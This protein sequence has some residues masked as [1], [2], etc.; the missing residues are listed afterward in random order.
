MS[1]RLYLLQRG[2]AVAMVPLI[3]VHL[4]LIFYAMNH[5]LTAASI[6]AR[7]QG[8][9][10]WGLFYG[11]FVLLAS[12]HASIGIR[13]ILAEWGSMKSR[14]AGVLAAVLGV[15]LVLLGLRAVAAVVL[16]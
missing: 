2:T 13:N 11:V 14:S 8:S 3:I 1:F 15:A 6:L 7:T 5:Q 16:P 12:T 9:I 4:A 10:A